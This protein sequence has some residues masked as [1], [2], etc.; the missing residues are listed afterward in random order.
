MDLLDDVK[1]DGSGEDGGEGE[2]ARGLAGGRPDGD[3]GT[4]GHFNVLW[5]RTLDG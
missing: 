2:R 5:C 3:G 4:S 1:P